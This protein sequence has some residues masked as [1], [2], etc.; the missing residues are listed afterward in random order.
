MTKVAALSDVHGN[1]TALA[2]T[3]ADAK[4]QGAD[5]FWFLGDLFMPGPGAHDV[6]EMLRELNVTVWLRGNW[7]DFMFAALERTVDY[8]KPTRVYTARLSAYVMQHMPKADYDFIMAL[9]VSDTRN[10]EDLTFT[11]SHN[12]PNKNAGHEL[13]P[14]SD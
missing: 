13:L 2:A 3:I 11:L 12:M 7:D 4:A 8:N 14:M 10:V 5:E 9:P 6:V 1:V